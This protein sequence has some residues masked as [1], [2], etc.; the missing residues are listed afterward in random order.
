[1]PTRG[2]LSAAALGLVAG[3]AALAVLPAPGQAPRTEANAAS[4]PRGGIPAGAVR[5]CETGILDPGEN[6]M[7]V[8]AYEL[9][10]ER[11]TVGFRSSDIMEEMTCDA[12]GG[13]QFWQ[14]TGGERCLGRPLSD[15]EQV[16]EL[17]EPLRGF[18]RSTSF[19][20]EQMLTCP[21]G[22]AMRATI[23][24]PDARAALLETRR[25][26]TPYEKLARRFLAAC[27]WAAS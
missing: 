25:G 7:N 20:V 5:T 24:I 3:L 1:M 2:L 23:S 4:P 19:A 13:V 11:L 9:C 21:A 15:S 27:G 16:Y 12:D 10:P 22:P 6:G 17:H 14:V 8:L 26:D 18:G